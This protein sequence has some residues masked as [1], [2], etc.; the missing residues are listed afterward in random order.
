MSD[1]SR[2]DFLINYIVDKLTAFLIEDSG[3]PIEQA[4]DVVYSSNLYELL[5]DKTADLTSE[6]PSHLYELLKS[7]LIA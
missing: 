4:L 6:S 7:Q 2:R 3:L 1:E 5:C